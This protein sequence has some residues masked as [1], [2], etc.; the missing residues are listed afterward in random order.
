MKKA[1]QEKAVKRESGRA[2]EYTLIA[3]LGLFIFLLTTFKAAGDD[4]MFWHLS[5]GRYIAETKTV[6]SADV[7]GYVTAGTPWIPIEWAWDTATYL[8]YTLASYDGLSVFRSIII[9]AQFFLLYLVLKQF[10]IPPPL[11]VLMLF[12]LAFGLFARFNIRPHLVTYLAYSVILLIIVKLRYTRAPDKRL[13]YVFPVLT[14]VWVNFHQGVYTGLLLFALYALYEILAKYV[15]KTD[16][17]VK[18]KSFIRLM[19][20]M[21]AASVIALLFNPHTYS[22][23][24][25]SYNHTQMKM[26]QFINEWKSPFDPMVSGDFNIVIYKIFLFAGLITLIYSFSKKDFFP[27]LVCSVFGYLSITAIRF[28][29]DYILIGSVFIFSSLYMLISFRGKKQVHP[30]IFSKPVISIAVIILLL[31]SSYNVPNNY[32]YSQIFKEYNTFGTN[33][34]RKFYPIRMFEFAKENRINEL[35]TTAFNQY[36]VGG[37][38]SWYFPGQKNLIDSRNLND[39]A[40]S[41]YDSIDYIKGNYEKLVK[42]L[43][44]DYALYYVPAMVSHPEILDKILI[45][46]FSVNEN[47]WKLVYWDDNSFIYVKNNAA[48]ADIINRYEYKL[49]TPYNFLNRPQLL[50]SEIRKGNETLKNEIQRKKTE[51]PQGEVINTMIRALR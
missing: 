24:L 35:G 3:A 12:V 6:P 40:F 45:S 5:T 13:L 25:Y 43:G 39:E 38:F 2:Y 33:I 17:F 8:I 34:D 11:I 26:L 28:N 23:I 31:V 15:L 32:I 44:I 51:E 7:F 20:L 47:D 50:L 29:I 46:Y 37:I 36:G 10:K 19:L 9:L 22:T 1:K 30:A 16:S 42:D 41:K 27:L 14:A 4:D 48:F 18:D 49:L 21:L